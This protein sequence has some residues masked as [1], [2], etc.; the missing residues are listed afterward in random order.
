MVSRRSSGLTYSYMGMMFSF[1]VAFSLM[2]FPLPAKIACLRP[3]FALLVLIYWVVNLPERSGLILAFIIGIFYDLLSGTAFGVMG[4]SMSVVAF[5][6]MNM[7]MRLRILSFMQHF[8]LILLLLV[9]SKVVHL[10]FQLALKQPPL[11]FT[12]WLSCISSTLCWPF[13]CNIL[14]NYQRILKIY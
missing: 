9:I 7:R 5:F 6:V 8:S 11:G 3:D 2:I 1:F 12:Y 13:V 10:C 14:N 4:L